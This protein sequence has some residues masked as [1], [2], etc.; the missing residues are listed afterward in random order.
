MIQFIIT[1]SW[2]LILSSLFIISLFHLTRHWI[3]I[4]PDNTKKIEG[5]ILKF[6]SYIIEMKKGEKRIYYLGNA[7]VKKW[8]MLKHLKPN[9][10]IKF[11]ISNEKYSLSLVGDTNQK[12]IDDL[13]SVLSCSTKWN[14][15]NLFLYIDDPIYMLPKWIRFPL[16][17]CSVCMA[18]VYGS[19][20]WWA[21]VYIQKDMFLWSNNIK[22]SYFY[23]WL[24]FIVVLSQIN[25]IV[26]RKTLEYV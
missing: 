26:Y 6:W 4:N 23:F 5:D 18:S 17:Q 7:L 14:D 16:S 11:Q 2:L 24:I 9:I 13:E 19:A 25:R 12:E 15:D 22:Y 21:F 3:I 1:F 8:E 20:I 10:A